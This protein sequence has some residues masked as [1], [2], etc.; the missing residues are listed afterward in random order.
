MN[1]PSNEVISL[2]FTIIQILQTKSNKF[3][4]KV[5]CYL[6]M[7]FSDNYPHS[8]LPFNFITDIVLQD[9]E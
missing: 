4:F 6:A 5:F 1:R 7:P 9:I 3:I 2:V 8:V